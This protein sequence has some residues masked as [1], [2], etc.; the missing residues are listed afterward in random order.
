MSAPL[1]ISSYN[2]ES[3]ALI[4]TSTTKKEE[5]KDL[6]SRLE[7]ALRQIDQLQAENKS[8]QGRVQVLEANAS[9]VTGIQTSSSAQKE[10]LWKDPAKN[11]FLKY[12]GVSLERGMGACNG[13]F[14]TIKV[15][16]G[17]KEGT[18]ESIY[19]NFI[20]PELVLRAIS[21]YFQMQLSST[22]NWKVN[23]DKKMSFEGYGLPDVGT[24]LYLH[25][26]AV[27][28]FLLLGASNSGWIDVG[29]YRPLMALKK[30]SD[31][32]L[33]LTDLFHLCQRYGHE[34]L[35]QQY[36]ASIQKEIFSDVSQ[37]AS[38]LIWAVSAPS[39]I[40]ALEMWQKW[41]TSYI[42]EKKITLDSALIIPVLDTFC[43]IAEYDFLEVDEKIKQFVF[44]VLRNQLQD[45]VVSG[46]FRIKEEEVAKK[47]CK[48]IFKL[49][50]HFEISLNIIS[51]MQDMFK[52]FPHLN[53]SS[54]EN[55][56][57][58][59]GHYI[60]SSSQ[61]FVVSADG[62]IEKKQWRIAKDYKVEEPTENS[63]PH[64]RE[65]FDLIQAIISTGGA[66]SRVA[67]M[68]EFLTKYPENM[69]AR[70]QRAKF[71]LAEGHIDPCIIECE[72]MLKIPVMHLMKY[73]VSELKVY[74]QKAKEYKEGLAKLA[75]ISVASQNSRKRA[76]KE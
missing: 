45:I 34:G 8:L 27:T 20:V 70:Y 26:Q 72:K 18:K 25:P 29:Q 10:E 11:A 51:V 7:E 36:M 21:S 54:E 23:T 37:L 55:L 58:G 74:A 39:Q 17:E 66:P 12:S 44:T 38:Y 53:S 75:E 28:Q 59:L 41:V 14:V 62:R 46:V 16:V 15:L 9:S 43:S 33:I 49:F 50:P 47:M 19:E 71:L 64:S 24:P 42:A 65:Y 69:L 63:D 76:K 30:E 1:K 57:L 2:G 35:K 56:I 61:P 73:P 13:P 52:K 4:T 31:F 48:C 67:V 68:T 60:Q 32:H 5:E 40:G 3:G 22:S 6:R